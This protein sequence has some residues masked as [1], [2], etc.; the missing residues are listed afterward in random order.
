VN[1]HTPTGLSLF[2]AE[3]PSFMM[4]NSCM[5]KQKRALVHHLLPVVLLALVWSCCCC[6]TAWSWVET[7]TETAPSSTTTTGD[8]Q[9]ITYDEDDA[10]VFNVVNFGADP[11]GISLSN[12]ALELAFQ[13]ASETAGAMVVIP[14]GTY[15]LYPLQLSYSNIHIHFDDGAVWQA[16]MDEEYI[17]RPP[18]YDSSDPVSYFNT[19]T[20]YDTST[21]TNE[22][23]YFWPIT[24]AMVTYGGGREDGRAMRYEAFFSVTGVSNVTISGSGVINGGGSVWWSL[25]DQHALHYTRPSL[26]E[27]RHSSNV[28]VHGIRLEK[29]PFWSLHFY[30][31]SHVL[32]HDIHIHNEILGEYK[33][34]DYSSQNVDG[35]DINSCNNV[36]IRDSTIH[37][38][39]DAIVIK[40][41]MD[42]AG[43]KAAIPS[44][45]ILV[46][47]VTTKS[48]VGAGLSIGSE[49]S[50]GISNVTFSNCTVHGSMYGIRVKTSHGRGATISD[51]TFQNIAIITNADTQYGPTSAIQLSMFGGNRPSFWKG[52]RWSDITTLQNFLFDTITIYPSDYKLP[53]SRSVATADTTTAYDEALNDENDPNVLPVDAARSGI[54]IMG[55]TNL[56][57]YW[58]SPFGSSS[59]NDYIRNI[60]FR[61]VIN[62]AIDD[63]TTGIMNRNNAKDEVAKKRTTATTSS[64]DRAMIP[65]NLDCVNAVNVRFD[66]YEI[67]CQDKP[68]AMISYDLDQIRKA[69]HKVFR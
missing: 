14:R 6:R 58:F 16:I 9:P 43:L 59:S 26:V 63:A 31:N 62:L 44:Y 51:I 7:E 61:S 3:T 67:S 12:L 17:L 55:D 52:F 38:H 13:A 35:I 41:G 11:T 5:V 37:T 25:L 50:G 45:N 56:R 20:D 32:V 21:D 53:G 15:L 47:N 18:T 69:I 57:R 64:S 54:H 27:I 49:V 65:S 34:I 29:S 2:T 28:L 1:S 10:T 23:M 42:L 4:L 40:S 22:M 48:P 68:Y 8:I 36:V 66:D 30:N 46:H 19:E 60:N 33:G 24:P 39:D